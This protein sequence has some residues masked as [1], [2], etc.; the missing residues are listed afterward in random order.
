MEYNTIFYGT[1]LKTDKSSGKDVFLFI[2]D[3]LD[4]VRYTFPGNRDFKLD[5]SENIALSTS[6]AINALNFSQAYFA[7][8]SFTHEKYLYISHWR[9][10]VEIC[11]PYGLEIEE[12]QGRGKL[13]SLSLDDC[14][15]L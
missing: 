13:V 15:E 7:W 4:M 5:F 10:G 2:L 8:K 9:G 1:N 11:F 14:L 3:N 6:E 12:R